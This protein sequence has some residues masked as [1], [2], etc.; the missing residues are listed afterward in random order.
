M[1]APA[2]GGLCHVL[3]EAVQAVPAASAVLLVPAVLVLAA[4]ILAAMLKVD[5]Q[6]D[7]VRLQ[8]QAVLTAELVQ[9]SLACLA[10]VV[11]LPAVE[12]PGVLAWPGQGCT[13][14]AGPLPAG[15]HY[16]AVEVM[17]AVPPVGTA[18]AAGTGQVPHPVPQPCCT[19]VHL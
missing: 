13:T 18:A 15:G 9:R 1:V 14:L 7:L 11:I 6:T 10:A 5:V 8:V 2:A 17:A 4:V 19:A 3:H 12:R 16:P